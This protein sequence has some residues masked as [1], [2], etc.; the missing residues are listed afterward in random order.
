MAARPGPDDPVT[1]MPANAPIRTSLD[2]SIPASP[3]ARPRGET[4]GARK[5]GPTGRP[6]YSRQAI[7]VSPSR[8]GVPSDAGRAIGTAVSRLARGRAAGSDARHPRRA[9]RGSRRWSHS[10]AERSAEPREP[11]STRQASVQRLHPAEDGLSFP[12]AASR[13]RQRLV[14]AAD[15]EKAILDRG[16]PHSQGLRPDRREGGGAWWLR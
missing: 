5:A 1:T 6:G 13:G 7:G 4:E 15:F 16:G 14:V 8:D 3:H 2:L 11:G 12:C 10:R 9:G